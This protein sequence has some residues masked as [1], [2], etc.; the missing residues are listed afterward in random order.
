MSVPPPAVF[1]AIAQQQNRHGPTP[2]VEASAPLPRLLV[3]VFAFYGAM[4][5][6]QLLLAIAVVA[7]AV[8]DANKVKAPI[9]TE[10]H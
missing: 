10:R 5:A 8:C 3:Y 1:L 2:P 6:M 4:A 9:A 7:R